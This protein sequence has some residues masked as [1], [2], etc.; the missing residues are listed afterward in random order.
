[1]KLF[2]SPHLSIYLT[3]NLMAHWPAR[4][5]APEK[6]NPQLSLGEI[7]STG[8]LLG[9]FSSMSLEMEREHVNEVNL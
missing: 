6:I 1:M 7:Q 2:L 3:L 5:E 9:L 8:N 4:E